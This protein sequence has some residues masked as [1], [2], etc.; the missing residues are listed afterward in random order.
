IDCSGFRGLLIE[1]TLRTGYE[2]W[3]HW[4][5]C[6]SAVAVAT[7]SAGDFS[8]YT[9]STARAAG[10][11]WRIP[12]QHRVGNGYVYCSR[13]VSDDEAAAT[14]LANVD[15]SPLFE[16][17]VLRFTAGQRRKIWN[18]NCIAIGLSGGFMEPLESTSILLI[19]T[20]IARLVDMFPDRSFD[21]VIINE[22]NRATHSEFERIRDFLILHYSA[23]ERDDAPLWQYCKSMQLP[24][25]LQHKIDVFRSSGRVVLYGDE[26]FLEPSWVSIFVGQGIQPRRYDPL[27]DNIP[28]ERLQRGLQQRRERI[29]QLAGAMPTLREYVAHNWPATMTGR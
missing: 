26:S 12:L 24:D 15:G 4:L 21:P 28:L 19:Q 29:R 27:V 6:D 14:L 5:P 1:Q 18:R 11:Q 16:P 17:R 23:T 9:T 22:Y 2:D 10:W 7:Q 20:C 8:P 13:H 3:S 25:T